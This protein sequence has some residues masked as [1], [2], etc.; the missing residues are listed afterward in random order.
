MPP[1]D[2]MSEQTEREACPYCDGLGGHEAG[3]QVCCGNAEWECGARGCTGPIDHR[4]L[5]QCEGCGGSASMRDWEV[6]ARLDERQLAE[7]RAVNGRLHRLFNAVEEALEF[8]DIGA[9]I[10]II[11][12]AR[13]PAAER[14]D[15][16]KGPDQ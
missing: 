8:R 5:E 15:H 12:Q 6:R 10:A 3:G 13:S 9:A 16:L 14:L 1:T 11:A 2:A 7:L 4:Y